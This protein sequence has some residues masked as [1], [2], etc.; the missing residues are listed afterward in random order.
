MKIAIIG[1]GITGLTLAYYLKKKNFEVKLFEKS[2]RLGGCIKTIH[3][4]GFLFELGPRSC[5]PESNG[6]YTLRLIEDLNLYEE[7]ISADSSS[8]K[9]FILIDQVL[10]ELPS[11]PFSFFK[12]PLLRGSYKKIFNEFFLSKAFYE[13]E[14]VYSFFSRRFGE[15]IAQNIIDPFISGI[16]AGDPKQ[17]SM[18]ACFPTL[19]NY[20]KNYGSVLK[21]FL[22]SK[23][24]H[25][26]YCSKFISE[27]KKKG[28]F[29]LKTGM[30]RLIQALEKNL[31]NEIHLNHHL[32]SIQSE[33]SKIVLNF[34]TH[35]SDTFDYLILAVPSK[36]VFK[37]IKINDS[38]PQSSLIVACIGYN[39]EVRHQ[40]GF[41]YLIPHSQQ[42]L[43]LGMVWDS[44]VFP[45]QNLHPHQTRFTAMLGGMRNRS[46]LEKNEDE[47]KEIIIESL[48]THL[49]IQDLPDYLSI[50][51]YYDIIPQYHLYHQRKLRL[52]EK[53]IKEISPN[54][55]LSGNN[56]YGISVNDCIAHAM[57]I[58]EKFTS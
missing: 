57:K 1:G 11:N 25:D 47:L 39:K 14:S 21:G 23:K 31:K 5:R 8:A 6:I 7:V 3:E 44:S 49:K 48:K 19:C 33:K 15:N 58:V 9:R 12:N 53:K 46:L 27:I 34:E 45:Q 18:K 2:N 54:I 51:K 35:P 17:L 26:P 24:I 20:E 13:D 56:F 30:E 37:I 40:K 28:L 4:E 43:L 22:L 50:H 41:G 55:I 29:S 36:E 32:N 38:I 16:Y 52:F 10:Q 42:E